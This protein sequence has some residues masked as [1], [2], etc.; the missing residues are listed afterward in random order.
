MAR[1]FGSSANPE[2]A[3][4]PTRRL[5]RRALLSAYVGRWLRE[6]L[7]HFIAIG[8]L[9]FTAYSVIGSP[10]KGPDQA[11]RIV[12]TADDLRQ[13]AVQWLAQG[14][15]L[16][17]RDEM[18]TLIRERVSE[19]ILS[20]EAVALGLDKNDEIIKRRLAQKM[21]FL[22]QDIA[23]LQ[24]PGDDELRAWFAQNS[25]RFALPPRLSFH[26][27]YFS[28]D[29]GRTA[30]DT[31]AAALAKIGGVPSDTA[32]AAAGADPFMFQDYYAERTPEQIT[33]E[34]GP[35]FAKTVFQ[36]KQGAWQGPVQSG[37]G[38][39]LVFINTIEP[40]R[41][42]AFEEVEPDVKSAWLDQKQ[43][44]IKRTAFE[45]MRQRYTVV[46][47]PIDSIDWTS[48]QTLHVTPSNVFPQ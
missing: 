31:A 47:A 38:W 16:P 25:S 42:P 6:P 34:F 21:D 36:L 26:H 12:L 5:E 7:F 18:T 35:S 17:T 28:A 45:A 40:G 19:E 43:S 14:R 48:L 1:L 32:P 37:Y 9:I 2:T 15:A 39:H 3:V 29:R 24:N 13:I 10:A 20:R 11:S 41:V 33:R 27:L 4:Q 44:E 46:V 22:A 30:R 8:A 23:A